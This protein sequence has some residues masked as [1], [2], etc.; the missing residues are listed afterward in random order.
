MFKSKVLLIFLIYG[1]AFFFHANY[2][3]A[4]D[5]GITNLPSMISDEPFEISVFIEGAKDGTNYLRVDMYKDGTS[6]YFGETFNGS[7]WYGGSEGISYFP[8]EIKSSST[9][10][11]VSAKIGNPSKGNYSGPGTYKLRVRRYTASGSSAQNDHQTPV[12]IQIT[13]N[14]PTEVP[15]ALP[16]TP[17]PV[18]TLFPEPTPAPTFIPTPKPSTPTLKSP[19]PKSEVLG[20]TE[21]RETPL[22]TSTDLSEPPAVMQ[23]SKNPFVLAIFLV[24]SGVGLTGYG[25]YMAYKKYKNENDSNG[26][27]S[28]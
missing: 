2:V 8:I 27:I 4:V 9:S 25:G 28:E 21:I 3:M 26:I 13:Y 24:F 17:Q 23:E 12:D 10:A 20:K 15:K 7:M 16:N 5:V 19:T 14:I 1:W 11:I 18:L 22:P 6:N